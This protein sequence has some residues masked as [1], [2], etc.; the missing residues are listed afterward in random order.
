[1]KSTNPMMH[2][3]SQIQTKIKNITISKD[4]LPNP[5]PNFRQIYDDMR[6]VQI[7]A[8]MGMVILA[9]LTLVG[10][11]GCGSGKDTV[12]K[13]KA[14]TLKVSQ[15]TSIPNQNNGGDLQYPYTDEETGYTHLSDSTFMYKNSLFKTYPENND[16]IY[17]KF[18]N[19]QVIDGLKD[20]PII[21]DFP[22]GAIRIDPPYYF[23]EVDLTKFSSSLKKSLFQQMKAGVKFSEIVSL[24]LEGSMNRTENFI[25]L[26]SLISVT[27]KLV[28]Y[29]NVYSEIGSI[30]Q[31]DIYNYE[32]RLIKTIKLD[33]YGGRVYPHTNEKYILIHTEP[34][35][36]E[37]NVD[38]EFTEVLI[39]IYHIE[40]NSFVKLNA[41]CSLLSFHSEDNF[42]EFHKSTST[43]T[44]TGI[45][46]PKEHQIFYKIFDLEEYSKYYNG[47]DYQGLKAKD[48]IKLEHKS[49]TFKEWNSLDLTVFEE[50]Q[51]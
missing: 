34:T 26:S 18:G 46:K 17:V 21:K 41:P 20:L 19:G 33:D 22:T 24:E 25:F 51:Y 35:E 1:M 13:T 4:K 30:G 2:F 44:L 31:I 39:R 8:M 10:C 49:A 14:D 11:Q 37:G 3:I 38:C 50:E 23:D 16:D 15:E 48:G 6:S 47:W 9:G 29:E 45:I 43:N 5:V 12:M 27:G 28:D 42:Y 7:H 36:G 32:G 40:N